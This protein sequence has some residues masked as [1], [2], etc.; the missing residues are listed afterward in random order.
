MTSI[1]PELQKIAPSAIIEL[2]EL[3]LVQ[4][5]HGSTSVYR[6][7]A[8]ANAKAGWG[9][10]TWNGNTYDRYPIQ[11]EGFEYTGNG[12]LPRPKL[13]ISNAL[14]LIS[15]VLAEINDFN[16]GSDLT[17][18]KLTRI[19]TCARYL[20]AVNF[21]DNINPYGTPD[22]TAETPREI[23][24]IDRKTLEN[25]D[26]VEF[27]LAAAFDLAGV[28]APKRQC[29]ANICQWVYRGAEC[30][31]TGTNYFN[32]KDQAVSSVSQDVCGK[33]LASCEA[34]FGLNNPLPFGSFPT[35]GTYYS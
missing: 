24:Y 28:R 19:R 16:R 29:I 25:R 2:F 15:A 23:Y 3:Q 17:G 6:F 26:V 11:V 18:A 21:P 5:L 7:H 9:L 20:D 32:E 14:G 10:V 12:Q 1:N 31:Y 35:V 27:E 4:A 8:G 33:R 22:P 30:G 34:R 13:R